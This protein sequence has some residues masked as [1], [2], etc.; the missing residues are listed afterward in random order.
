MA[1]RGGLTFGS[2]DPVLALIRIH[3]V[4]DRAEVP[5]YFLESVVHHE[6]LHHQLGGEPDKAGRTIYHS[7]AFRSAE[8]RYP[9]HTQALD[10]E[11]R[12]LP[13]LLRVAR[14]IEHRRRREAEGTR[15]SSR[16]R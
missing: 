16:R 8:A 12:N 6:M 15:C 11:K 2:Y 14:A 4:L 1:R 3:P 10:W 5:R 13:H 9:L 7:K